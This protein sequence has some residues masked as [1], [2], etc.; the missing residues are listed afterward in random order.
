MKSEATIEITITPKGGG[1]PLLNHQ[2]QT[3]RELAR[4][5]VEKMAAMVAGLPGKHSMTKNTGKDGATVVEIEL[6]KHDP[7]AVLPPTFRQL[8]NPDEGDSNAHPQTQA[9]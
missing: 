3:S 5:F 8:F 2:F 4:E 1:P 6:N 7:P 9:K